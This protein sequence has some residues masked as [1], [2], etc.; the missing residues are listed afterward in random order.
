MNF[1]SLGD[2]NLCVAHCLMPVNTCFI[3]FVCFMVAHCGNASLTS[4]IPSC[5]LGKA[6]LTIVE[7]LT[8]VYMFVFYTSKLAV[9]CMVI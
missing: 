5:L 9:A 3:H 8:S 7:A 1:P 4:A 6:G 2:Y